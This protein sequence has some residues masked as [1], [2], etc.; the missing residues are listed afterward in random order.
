MARGSSEI[1]IKLKIPNAPH[2]RRLLRANGFRVSKRR[3]FEAN[4]VFDTPGLAL[5]KTRRLLRVR[6]VGRESI[7]TYKGAPVP[8]KHKSREELELS[9]SD[10]R[11][12]AVILDRLGY[13]PTFLYEKYRTTYRELQVSGEVTLDE[14][15][16]G[17][18]LELE[19][20]PRWIDRTARRLGFTEDDYILDSYGRL[21][22]EWCKVEGVQPANM[23]FRR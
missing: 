10:G 2:G 19:G 20:S 21:Y 4:T 14:T 8:S 3:V 13:R 17:V 16:I 11:T 12:F 6:H 18:F 1:E 9:L 7:L 15:P 23:Q 22:L 5:R